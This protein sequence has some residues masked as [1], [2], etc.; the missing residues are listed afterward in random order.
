MRPFTLEKILKSSRRSKRGNL[1]G[2][3][4]VTEHDGVLME[5]AFLFAMTLRAIA[6]TRVRGQGDGEGDLF[7]QLKS[8]FY[9]NK[10][11]KS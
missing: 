2:G 10:F 1:G 4:R 11:H 7:C 3:R 9:G 6:S 8:S 5:L